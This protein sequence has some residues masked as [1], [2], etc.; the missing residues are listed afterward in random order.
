MELFELMSKIIFDY[1][2]PLAGLITVFIGVCTFIKTNRLHKVRYVSCKPS[3]DFWKGYELSVCIENCTQHVIEVSEIQLVADEKYIINVY[4]GKTVLIKP[5]RTEVIKSERMSVYPDEIDDVLSDNL[6]K[7]KIFVRLSNEKI[8]EA[9]YSKQSRKCNK[10]LIEKKYS[11]DIVPVL[12][13][14]YN[15]RLVPENVHYNVTVL[16]EKKIV[17]DSLIHDAGHLEICLK[18]YTSINKDD[19]KNK[20]TI[21]NAIETILDDDNLKVIVNKIAN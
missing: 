21:K 4:S 12:C 10:R 18:G 9:K 11:Y 17:Y 2:I 7:T 20:K 1:F 5:Y 13:N 8:L 19:M 3:F 6:L 15:N 16:R 14:Y